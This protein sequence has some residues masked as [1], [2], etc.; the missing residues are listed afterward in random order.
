MRFNIDVM[1]MKSGPAQQDF[2]WGGLKREP[3]FFFGGG[4]P[5]ACY[6]WKIWVLVTLSYRK[7][8]LNCFYNLKQHWR[9]PNN[10]AANEEST[11]GYCNLF[12]L[13]FELALFRF[14]TPHR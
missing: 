6:P 4:G 13:A 10:N 9:T 14:V 2:D 3:A 12:A 5:V 1:Y 8:V 7:V 11:R